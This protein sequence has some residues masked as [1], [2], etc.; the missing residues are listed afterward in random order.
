MD[1]ARWALPAMAP[2][3]RLTG[4]FY[5]QCHTELRLQNN[6]GRGWAD[7]SQLIG[8]VERAA[9]LILSKLLMPWLCAFLHPSASY[10]ACG[11]SAVY[12]RRHF[13]EDAWMLAGCL[14][15]KPTLHSWSN[16]ILCLFTRTT[17][18]FKCYS[19]PQNTPTKWGKQHEHLLRSF[20]KLT[21]CCMDFRVLLL[22]LLLQYASS[23]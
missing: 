20:I 6:S 9:T 14:V 10:A 22:L 8:C 19:S 2:L 1:F 23:P 15:T 18:M 12:R 5:A 7:S 3:L 17:V 4:R 21:L 11:L 16:C 13:A